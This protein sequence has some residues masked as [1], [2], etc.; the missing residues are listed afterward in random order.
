MTQDDRPHICMFFCDNCLDRG[1]VANVCSQLGVDSR[2][3]IRLPCSGKVNIQY[4][5]KAFE[6]GADGVVLLTCEMG[7][8]RH[9]EGNRRAKKRAEA[10]DSLLD[11]IGIGTG[12]VAAGEKAA[13]LLHGAGGPG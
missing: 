7:E 12:R 5:V 4:L 13:A 6:T 9:L 11:E 2:M 1:Q 8:C 3:A 10:V